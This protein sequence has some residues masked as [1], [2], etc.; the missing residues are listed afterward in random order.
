[1]NKII[2]SFSA[3]LI[4]GL[5]ACK[6]KTAKDDQT[7]VGTSPT[8]VETVV[9]APKLNEE[10]SF[11][12][13]PGS[14]DFQDM[15]GTIDPKVDFYHFANGT[16]VKNNPVPS[17]E[18]RWSSFNILQDN[19]NRKLREILEKCAAKNNT[20]GDYHQII[21]D[22]YYTFMDSVK[23]DK[24]GID[25]IKGE[26]K[27]ID[28]LA[29]KKDLAKIIAHYH[30][31]GIAPLFGLSI[32]QDLKDINLNITYVGQGGIL[33]PNN[34]YYLKTDS[35]SVSLRDKYVSH[36]TKM[37]GFLGYN[38]MKAEKSARSVL[39]FET[40]L[41]RASMGPVE[42]RDI[43]AQYNKMTIDGLKKLNPSFDW[44]V[45]FK[46]RGIPQIKDVVVGQTKFFGLADSLIKNVSLDVWKDYLKIHFFEAAATKLSSEIEKEVFDFFSTQLRGARKMKLRWERAISSISW[47]PI[48]EALG[49]AFVDENFKPEAKQKVNEMVDNIMFVFRE[50]LDKLEWMSPATKTRALEKLASFSRKLGY[51]DKWTDYS[52]L[53]IS[54]ESYFQNWMASSKFGVDHNMHKYGK[55]IDRTEWLMAPHIVNAYY[56]PPWNEIVFP[57]GIM[58]PPFFVIDAEDAVN[59]ARMGAV[60][61]HE[62]LHGFDDQGALFDASGKFE[63]WWTSEDSSKFAS[64]TK[65]LVEHFNEFEALP[66]IFVNGELTL[67]ENI[68]DLGGLTMAYY[69]YQRSLEG[70][71]RKKINGFS[72]EQR[73]FIAFAQVWKENH[74]EKSMKLQ[75]FTNPHSP[76]KYRVLGPLSNM[77]EFFAAFNVKEGDP[78]RRSAEKIAL[79]W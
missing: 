17:T 75:V 33:L 28:A 7:V 53:S 35:N 32:D 60:I 66:G 21:G 56:N 61:G 59:Y 1:M 22:Y 23:R 15:D 36:L 19:N 62:F 78:M 45:Y 63:N 18:S 16:W 6:T 57:A 38:N 44:N 29:S 68:A 37:F 51:P 55:P 49:H 3:F 27:K 30:N 76:G 5:G 43:D 34:E 64:K 72:P 11:A 8:P 9:P 24:E 48:A 40:A 54:R 70:K 77:P 58:Q 25:P 14:V 46:E 79:I 39:E 13:V 65:K 74:T 12:A 73:F 67:G 4:L 42:L 10:F 31:Y 20:K 2:F 69:A 47:S 26:L 52:K 71:E 50:R 41:A